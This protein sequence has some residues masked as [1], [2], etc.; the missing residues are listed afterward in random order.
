MFQFITQTLRSQTILGV[1]PVVVTAIAVYITACSEDEV[2]L[3]DLVDAINGEDIDATRSFDA[4]GTWIGEWNSRQG[5]EGE[6]VV[7]V[8]QQGEILTG[9][10]LL[11]G[12]PCVSEV[13]IEGAIDPADGDFQFNFIDPE[14][15]WLWAGEFDV[16][17][18]TLSASF[19]VTNWG[20]CTTDVGVL[21]ATRQ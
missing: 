10:V 6:A 2:P 18:E 3:R 19:T 8:E 13:S 7:T 17:D 9:S 4:T 1:V 16:N 21:D 15:E 14:M 20:F 12:T 11:T 5:L